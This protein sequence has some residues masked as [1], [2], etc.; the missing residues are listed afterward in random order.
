MRSPAWWGPE[1]HFAGL[2]QVRRFPLHIVFL[3]GILAAAGSSAAN[4]L[5]Y[6]SKSDLANEVRNRK[7]DIARTKAR[8]ASLEQAERDAKSELGRA[9]VEVKKIEALVTVRAKMFY[10]LHRNGGGLRYLLGSSSAIELLRRLGELRHLLQS[11][12]ESRKQAG[13][14]LAKAEN[15]LEST[16]KEKRAAFAML[17]LL[18][19]TLKELRNELARRDG[20]NK[21]IAFR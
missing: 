12:L 13:I 16:K 1:S 15:A 9:N 5:E 4:D 14:R 21:K 2:Q 8:I 6:A 20:S 18:K 19:K 3:A 7:T 10:R 11:C 17:S